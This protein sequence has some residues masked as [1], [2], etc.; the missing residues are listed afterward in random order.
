MAEQIEVKLYTYLIYTY[1]SD[2]HDCL[3]KSNK[4]FTHMMVKVTWFGSHIGLSKNLFK[5]HFF[6]TA[7]SIDVKLRKNDLV[8]KRNIGFKF[9]PDR[10]HGLAVRIISFLWSGFFIL[11]FLNKAHLAAPGLVWG[12]WSNIWN[13]NPIQLPPHDSIFSLCL[14]GFLLIIPMQDCTYLVFHV[15]WIEFI[16]I[17]N[18]KFNWI[19]II[20]KNV[21][22]QGQV[23]IQ[24]RVASKWDVLGPGHHCQQL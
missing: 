3:S 2:L 17:P 1:L 19:I 16:L 13:P 24:S 20:F 6:W 21:M 23:P 5:N 10:T 9:Q 14:F 7:S 12:S 15:I 11:F 4:T 8:L 18:S 22:G